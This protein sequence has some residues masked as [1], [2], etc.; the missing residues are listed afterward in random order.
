L[1]GILKATEEQ[2][3]IQ[4]R[5]RRI[6]TSRIRNTVRNRLKVLIYVYKTA[7]FLKEF[8]MVA[9]DHLVANELALLQNVH[10]Q[11]HL[12][13]ELQVVQVGLVLPGRNTWISTQ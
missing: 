12:A 7:L 3:R 11:D 5:I 6:K 4:I 10:E 13:S 1:V 8:N 2:S 9:N